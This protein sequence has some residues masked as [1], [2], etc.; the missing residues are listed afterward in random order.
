M[1]TFGPWVTILGSV[2]E[3]A[4]TPIEKF[5]PA[6]SPVILIVS[7]FLAVTEP[8]CFPSTCW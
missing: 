4:N 6:I 7:V 3:L 2:L 8:F 5:A 1:V